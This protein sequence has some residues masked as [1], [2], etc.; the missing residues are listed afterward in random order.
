MSN[1]KYEFDSK[2]GILFKYHTGE[3]SYKDISDS[4]D[5]AKKNN[6]IPK[7]I[8]GIVVDFRDANAKITISDHEKIAHF[9]N[10]N[11]EIFGGLKI[12]VILPVDPKNIVVPIM[13]SEKD[14][15]YKSKP[16]LTYEAA[17]AWI[18]E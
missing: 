18:L 15:G 9:F 7:G 17:V 12:A 2:T 3:V 16:F 1:Y 13:V 11:L 4:W 5:F 14:D 10:Q 6:L 8:R